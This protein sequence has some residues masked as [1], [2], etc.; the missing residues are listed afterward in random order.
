MALQGE[1]EAKILRGKTVHGG[2]A[3]AQSVDKL[4]LVVNSKDSLVTKSRSGEVFFLLLELENTAL[5]AVLYHEKSRDHGPV[6][7][8]SMD[9]V[10]CLSNQTS[11]KTIPEARGSV[12]KRFNGLVLGLRDSTK[13][14]SSTA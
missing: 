1:E 6:L 2:I 13:D 14:L 7:T 11:Q 5:D 10:H 3:A 9:P 8:D 12:R 4:L